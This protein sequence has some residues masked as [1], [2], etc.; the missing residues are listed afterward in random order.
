M[1]IRPSSTPSISTQ[2]HRQPLMI[3]ALRWFW[4]FSQ[5]YGEYAV[6]SPREKQIWLSEKHR[7]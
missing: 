7:Q 2:N 6:R 1:I 3:K 4:R 5:F